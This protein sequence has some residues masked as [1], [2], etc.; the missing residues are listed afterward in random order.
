LAFEF[1]MTDSAIL[2]AATPP[3]THPGDPQNPIPV[4]KPLNSSCA[5]ARSAVKSRMSASG[6]SSTRLTSI[7]APDCI[8]INSRLLL[9]ST[10]LEL[11]TELLINSTYFET[12]GMPGAEFSGKLPVSLSCFAHLFHHIDARIFRLTTL[13][14]Y[15]TNVPQSIKIFHDGNM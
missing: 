7:C 12:T 6:Y 13:Y 4:E 8:P 11:P 15:V 14:P 1:A 10:T 3:I 5:F 2:R 9:P